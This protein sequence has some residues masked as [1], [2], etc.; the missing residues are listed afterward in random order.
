MTARFLDAEIRP[1]AL[2]DAVGPL[3]FAVVMVLVAGAWCALFNVT[4][5]AVVPVFVPAF[6]GGLMAKA[7]LSLMRAPRATLASFPVLALRYWI[8]HWIAA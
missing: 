2:R 3:A 4:F 6:L 1:I 5:A 7:G 8:A